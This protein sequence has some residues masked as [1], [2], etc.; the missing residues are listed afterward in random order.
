VIPLDDWVAIT[1]DWLEEQMPAQQ[2][3]DET[4]WLRFRAR[5][6]GPFD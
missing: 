4:A 2:A 1:R 3:A 6:L 5:L